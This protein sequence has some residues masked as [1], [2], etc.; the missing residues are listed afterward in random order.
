[1]QLL[2]IALFLVILAVASGT[3]LAH[4][5]ESTEFSRMLAAIDRNDPQAVAQMLNTGVSVNLREDSRASPTLLT[6][7]AMHGR[8]RISE[9]LI[10]SGARLE[11][12]DGDGCTALVVA[13]SGGHAETVRM[14]LGRGA[15]TGAAC[16]IR[17]TAL[18]A[19]TAGRH[20]EVA[21]ILKAAG[22]TR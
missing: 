20:S 7:A 8:K 6:Y 16:H 12:Q 14:L 13:A 17:G 5:Q 15:S 10:Q 9:L 22:A 3:R 18:A 19:A 1:M 11:D 21:G 4:A 2:S